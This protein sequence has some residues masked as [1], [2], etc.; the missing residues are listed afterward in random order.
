V[1]NL[2]RNDVPHA[3]ELT[4]ASDASA[5]ATI[6]ASALATGRL[7]SGLEIT[8][9]RLIALAFAPAQINMVS[10]RLPEQRHSAPRRNVG[11]VRLN[12]GRQRRCSS[13]RLQFGNGSRIRMNQYGAAGLRN[14]AAQA[15][16]LD[17]VVQG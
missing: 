9:T 17:P 6:A 5:S 10:H 3:T 14:A 13:H 1:I 2:P 7:R 8:S 15:A 4:D 11:G 16:F 12:G